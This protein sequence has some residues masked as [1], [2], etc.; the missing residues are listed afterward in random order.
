MPRALRQA[1]VGGGLSY[2][3]GTPAVF[4]VHRNPH[5]WVCVCVCGVFVLWCM[6]VCV[7]GVWSLCVCVCL[8]VVPG[9]WCM[10]CV[11]WSDQFDQSQTSDS[12]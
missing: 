9:V 6:R 1:L 11:A 5:G 4:R 8:C 2:D 12:P 10:V 7:F 3:P